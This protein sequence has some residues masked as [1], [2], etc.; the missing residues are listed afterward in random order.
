MANLTIRG[1]PD[2]VHA[3]LKE[4]AKANRRS[5]NQEVVAEL[6]ASGN[7]SETERIERA[8][9]RMSRAS[10]EI[11]SIRAKMKRFMTTEEI[12]TAIKEDRQ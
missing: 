1:L 10:A 12:D 6:I 9:E 5:L 7:N 11:D 8:R 2:E 3:R 4:R